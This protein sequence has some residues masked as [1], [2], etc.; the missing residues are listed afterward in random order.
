MGKRIFW[1]PGRKAKL[2]KQA[3][4]MTVNEMARYHLQPAAEI[5]RMIKFLTGDATMIKKRYK[6]GKIVVTVYYAAY[7]SGVRRQ[8]M[9]ERTAIW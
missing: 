9:G 7:A 5:E 2:L 4:I 6:E 3:K 1:T 8:C